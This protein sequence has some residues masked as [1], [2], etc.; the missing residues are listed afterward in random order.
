MELTPLGDPIGLTPTYRRYSDGKI[1]TVWKQKGGKVRRRI[2]GHRNVTDANAPKDSRRT[3][4]FVNT[5]DRPPSTKGK[6]QHHRKKKGGIL[7]DLI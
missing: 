2:T 6:V 1:Y 7:D 3:S 5:T 4:G